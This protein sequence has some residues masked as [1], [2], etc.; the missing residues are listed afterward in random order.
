[1]SHPARS[2][3]DLHFVWSGFLVFAFFFCFSCVSLISRMVLVNLLRW[4]HFIVFHFRW[5]SRFGSQTLSL[6]LYLSIDDKVN[7][8]ITWAAFFP[9][10]WLRQ[11]RFNES[12]SQIQSAECVRWNAMDFSSKQASYLRAID[13]MSN[14]TNQQFEIGHM[15]SNRDDL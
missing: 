8:F 12:K 15:S 6:S 1:M 10:R 11:W 9:K 2:R 7:I 4:K 13:I 3:L 14:Q 5:N